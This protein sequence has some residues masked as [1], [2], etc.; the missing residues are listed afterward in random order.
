[1]FSRSRVLRPDH[2]AIAKSR[3]IV[4]RSERASGSHDRAQTGSGKIAGEDNRSGEVASAEYPQIRFALMLMPGTALRL[5]PCFPFPGV[6]N[7]R[8][9]TRVL[10][11]NYRL[12]TRKQLREA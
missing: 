9:N 5:I 10:H 8:R 3:R 4:R 11:H 12:P 2:R 6:P 1:L 7:T